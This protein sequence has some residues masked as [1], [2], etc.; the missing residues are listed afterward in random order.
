MSFLLTSLTS[1]KLTKKQIKEICKLK[2]QQWRYRLQS[3]INHFKEN[4]K[5]DDIH[6]LFYIN[7]KLI[8]YTLLR[9]RTFN[10]NK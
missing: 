9:K 8:G 4:I 7:T 10:L 2:N 1:S 3:H 5:R 6:N